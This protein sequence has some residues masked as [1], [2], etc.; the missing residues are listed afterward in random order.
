MTLMTLMT[1]G[2]E[3]CE[4]FDDQEMTL[5]TSKPLKTLITDDFDTLN[6]YLL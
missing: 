5:M 3:E 2:F 1:Y 4:G 6:T